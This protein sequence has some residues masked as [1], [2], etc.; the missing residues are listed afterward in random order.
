MGCVMCN[1]RAFLS[2]LSGMSRSSYTFLLIAVLSGPVGARTVIQPNLDGTDWHDYS[3]P[4]LVIDDGQIY[5]TLPGGLGR[6]Y[7]A[8]GYYIDDGTV[9]QSVIP[10]T[11]SRDFSEPSFSIRRDEGDW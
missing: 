9:Y 7:S 10:G 2:R 3:K 4:S 1:H 11:R 6:D 8:P 5:Q